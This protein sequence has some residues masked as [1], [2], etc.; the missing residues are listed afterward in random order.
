MANRAVYRTIWVSST[1]ILV[2]LIVLFSRQTSAVPT[3]DKM[4][5]Y[6]TD[7]KVVHVQHPANWQGHAIS[8]NAVATTVWFQPVPTARFR[9]MVDL[10]GSLLADMSRSTGGVE[11]P[12]NL[13][14]MDQGNAPQ[15]PSQTPLEKVHALQ[16]EEMQNSP[17]YPQFQDGATAPAQI[18]G[19]DALSTD[20]TYQQPGLWG[21][22]PIAGK[23]FTALT[24][25]RRVTVVYECPKDKQAELTPVFTKMLES[26]QIG[27]GGS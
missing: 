27:Q 7:D 3:P 8:A 14:G 22:T 19:L 2:V 1:I 17:L 12:S 18:A 11:L 26:L 25:D 5:T 6:V 13:P 10:K 15:P 21:S 16:G 24:G 23:R 4:V 20:Y 9:I